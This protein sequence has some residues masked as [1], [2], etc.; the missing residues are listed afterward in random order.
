M[1]SNVVYSLLYDFRSRV[2]GRDATHAEQRLIH[3][4]LCS[5]NMTIACNHVSRPSNVFLIL[6]SSHSS[7]Y[8]ALGLSAQ[9]Y[10]PCRG[11]DWFY[12]SPLEV[13]AIQPS[14]TGF[15]FPS[16]H[17]NTGNIVI[18]VGVHWRIHVGSGARSVT[19]RFVSP[20]L[21]F[22]VGAHPFIA[23]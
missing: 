17:M 22:F 6:S 7:R 12:R 23:C 5:A 1:V 2:T 8:C 15:Q 9:L 3:H 13:Y 4:A 10:T 11:F 21:E 20:T 16:D 14:A 19:D 18:T